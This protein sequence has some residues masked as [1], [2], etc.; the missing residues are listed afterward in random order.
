MRQRSILHCD[1]DKYY[2]AVEQQQNPKL[3][4]QR[5]AVCGSKEDRHGIVLTASAEAKAM[6]V[7][8]GQAIWEAQRCCRDLIIVPPH[9]DEY[10]RYSGYIRDILKDYTDQI[11][12]FGLDESWIDVTG[13]VGLFG[14][15]MSIAKEIS[16]RVRQEIGITV[17]IGVANNKVFAKLGSDYKK[18]NGITRIE[19]DNF[20]DVVYPLPVEDLLYVGPATKRKLNHYCIRTIGDLAGTDPEVLH[21]WLGKMG[22]ILS[23]F[24]RGQD[25][26]PVMKMEHHH[27]VKSVGNSGT[28]PRDLVNDPDAWL[29]IMV[30]AESVAAR[31]RELNM[32]CTVVEVSVRD[33]EMNGF[34]RQQKIS[35]PTNVSLEI[36]RVA[37]ALFKQNY[38]WQKPLRGIGVRGADLVPD[39]TPL[40]LNLFSDENRRQKR[41]SIERA[42]DIV[43]GRYGYASI[44]RAVLYT[45]TSL[46]LI[47]PK[48]DHTIHPVGYF[49]A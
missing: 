23:A 28:M 9:Y 26:S 41:E 21:G 40:Q 11:E 45:D 16:R 27:T 48:D 49:S 2:V 20:R 34:S 15:G 19:D 13:S 5:V 12:S 14:N 36:A 6:G 10:V 25:T 24:A 47:N 43:R 42:V 4:G 44:L 35:Q 32:K 22:Y 30:M 17:S 8:T 37:F 18:P 38:H 46:G 31:L 39:N 1:A 3:R 7:K 29:V 33:N